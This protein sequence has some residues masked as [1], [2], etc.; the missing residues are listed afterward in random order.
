MTIANYIYIAVISSY[1]SKSDWQKWADEEI[2][3][4]AYK[5]IKNHMNLFDKLETVNQKHLISNIIEFYY[6]L[7]N[8]LI[9]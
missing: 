7:F 8:T 5:I 1:Y 2:L 9:D 6:Y 3:N 4:N